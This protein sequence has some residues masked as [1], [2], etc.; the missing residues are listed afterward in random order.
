MINGRYELIEKIGEGRSSVFLCT[1][2]ES[3]NQKIALKVLT[4]SSN[5][6]ELKSFKN[7]F[8]NLKNL[9]HP[10]IVKAIERGTILES[11]Y[12]NIPLDSKYFTLEYFPGKDLFSIAEYS[13]DDLIEIIIQISSV[14]FYLHQSNFIYFDLK[15]ENILISFLNGKPQ[16][17]LIDFG[18]ARHNQNTTDNNIFGTAEYIAP[19]LLKR[20]VF[21]HRVDL[22]SFGMLL[23]RLIYNRFPFDQ[24]TE[25]GIYKAQLENGFEFPDSRFSPQII[26]IV[27]KLL[28]KNPSSRYRNS[29]RILQDIDPNIIN[30]A[31]KIWAPANIFVDRIEPYSILINYLNNKSSS[32]VY[33]IKGSEGS[34]KSSLLNIIYNEFDEAILISYSKAK[35]GIDFIKEFFLKILFNEKV[36]YSISRELKDNI[37]DII[38]SP[39][40]DIVE[41]INALFSKL[42]RE[43]NFIILFDNFNNVDELTYDVLKNIIPILQV[44]NRKFIFAENPEVAVL[45]EGVS[46]LHEINLASFTELDINKFLE[47]GYFKE[48]PRDDLKK[49]ILKYADLLPGNIK[50][51][52]KDI[53][54][55][56]ILDYK[57]DK[58]KI[59]SDENTNKLLESSQEDIYELRILSLSNQELLVAELISLFEIAIDQKTAAT[60]L[61]LSAKEMDFIVSSL[62]QKNIILPVHLRNILNFTSE[63][64]KTNVY[65]KVTN[66]KKLHH[67]TAQSIRLKITSFNRVELARQ[68]ELAEDYKE[69]YEVIKEELSAAEKISA[70]SYNK[71]ILQKYITFP[72]EFEDKFS[73]KSHLVYVLYNLSEFGITEILINELLDQNINEGSKDELLILKGSCLIGSGNIEEGKNLLNQLVV[74]IDDEVKILKLLA[75]VANAEYELNNYDEAAKICLKII[76]HNNADET[77]K[78]KCYSLLGMISIFKENNLGSALN[79]FVLAEKYYNNK[80]LNFKV[81]QMEKNIGNVYNMKGEYNKAEDYWNKSLE[82]SSSSG[83]LDLEAKLLLNFGVYYFENLNFDKAIDYYNRALSIFSSLGNRSG[84]GLVK[85][86]LG[87]IYLITCEFDNAIEAIENSIKIFNNLK[88]LNEEMESLFLLGKLSFI[89]GDFQNLSIVIKIMKNKITDEKIVDKHKTNYNF[90]LVLN[91]DLNLNTAEMIKSFSGIKNRYRETEDKINYFFTEVQLINYLI[92]LQKFNEAAAELDDDYF[93]ALCSENKLFNAERNYM[94]AILS[95]KSKSFGNSIDYLLE[96]FNYIN[97]SGITELSWK[98][99][100]QLAEIYFERGNYSKSEEFN[101]F[102]ISVLDYIFN[103]I[104]NKNIRTVITESSERKEIYKRLLMMQQ[105]Y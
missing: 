89:I 12:K 75:E 13:E 55:L 31:A 11:S 51:F 78:G 19:E 77:E 73:L 61:D 68:F 47:K 60:I 101:T 93:L 86:N 38:S 27:K 84:Q 30:T 44:N 21:D 53:L 70:Y 49:I 26:N 74:K 96:A 8:L 104:K 63:G 42:S 37:K 35:S 22:Y 85:Y 102:A 103:S 88:N 3:F 65:N 45:S 82:I 46:E 59:S 16:I 71:K 76:N 6:E 67:F 80:G 10:N 50:T 62:L 28:S 58:I 98:V 33:S 39:P 52:L 34:G 92:N 23:Y 57:S 20:E 2:K 18:L 99:L 54:L 5:P 36:F 7:E 90:L 1:D 91:S 100:Y 79:N 95:I 105:K 83:N 41:Q 87:E 29:I 72:L 66:K 94:F 14:L 40:V 17:K 9:E 4:H 97:E 81:A 48:F 69:S 24:N 43:C 25:M 32:E 64:L 56:D 15:P